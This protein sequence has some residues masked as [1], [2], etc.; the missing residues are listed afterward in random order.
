MVNNGSTF[1]IGVFVI[2]MLFVGLSLSEVSIVISSYLIVSAIGQ[3]PAGIFADRHGYKTSLIIGSLIYLCGT[4]F[5]AF[6]QD[7]YWF[8]IGYSL[9]GFGW[10]I[11]DLTPSV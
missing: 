6:A 8:L 7:F 4:L 5:F 1:G 10:S 11:K 9:M 2:F 3:I